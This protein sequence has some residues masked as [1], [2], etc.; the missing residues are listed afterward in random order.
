MHRSFLRPGDSGG[1]NVAR[2]TT[3]GSVTIRSLHLPKPRALIQQVIR[4]LGAPTVLSSLTSTS[5]T[6]SRRETGWW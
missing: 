6:S 5:M 2:V 3:H 1:T 4:Q